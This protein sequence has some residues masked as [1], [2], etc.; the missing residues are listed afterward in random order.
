MILCP[1]CNHE[2][3][4]EA[5]EC[6]ACS[7]TLERE[8]AQDALPVGTE[9]A[10]GRYCIEALLGRG[11]FA[12]TYR[13]YDRHLEEPVAIK[14]LLPTDTR[15]CR[16]GSDGI[17]VVSGQEGGDFSRVREQFKQEAKLLRKLRHPRVVGCVHLF[18]ANG[19]T[20]LVM[21]LV[22]GRT[23]EAA[24]REQSLE[25]AEALRLFEQLLEGVEAVHEVGLVHRDIN[26]R[27]IM[28]EEGSDQPVL[29]DFGLARTSG[30]GTTTVAFTDGYTALEQYD[31]NCP[32]DEKLD[33]YSL[34]AVLYFL[35]TGEAPPSAIQRLQGRSL[36]WPESV[37]EPIRQAVEQAMALQAV[38][39]L[40]NVAAL[41]MALSGQAAS[42]DG[43]SQV[44]QTTRNHART[45][46][47]WPAEWK[48][49]YGI[50]P[51]DWAAI[52]AG[53]FL[54]GSPE[55]EEERHDNER[56][57]WVKVSAFDMLKTPV[58]FAM[59]DRFCEATGR[60]KPDD[61]GWGRADRPVINVSYWDAVDYC[62]WLSGET[63][64][65]IRLPTEAEWEYAC[66]AGTE[67]PFWTG[68]TISTKQANYDGHYVYGEDGVW[69]LRQLAIDLGI[70]P[71]DVYRKRT[72]PV[73]RFD[74]NPWGLHDMH[75]NVWEWCASE[76]DKR[77][78]GR[79]CQD[80]S[81]DRS[82]D[83]KRVLRGG[84]WH[85]EPGWLRSASRNWSAPDNRNDNRGFRLA[86]ARRE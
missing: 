21:D 80:A 35:V 51:E 12:V 85:N 26:P 56:Q 20:Y 23:L 64:W 63:G 78:G 36:R 13:A 30:E 81:S 71:K 28:L 79:E 41:R 18:E 77:Y 9:L 67:T 45:K 73:D 2:N 6:S 55:D 40:E 10:D 34:G 76:Y 53:K 61:L 29:I 16:R 15:L 25:Q 39:R 42:G 69:M 8:E 59:Y 38:E 72:T 32:R 14:E 31:P 33:I 60:E 19:T 86:R 58:T 5:Q 50:G 70:K 47:D 43:Q 65:K 44:R 22:K 74:S 11:G 57:H 7:T 24:I 68:E 46:D 37:E 62:E 48:E 4:P 3:A 27:N 52:P 83:T 17:T 49:R 54:M 82:N 1:V 66:R 84:S 75:G